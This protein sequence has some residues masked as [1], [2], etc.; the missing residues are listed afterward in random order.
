MKKMT[1]NEGQVADGSLSW[2]GG[3]FV[4]NPRLIQSLLTSVST[5]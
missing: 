3:G 1:H 5:N 4:F 2:F